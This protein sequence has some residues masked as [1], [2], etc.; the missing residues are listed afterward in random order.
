MPTASLSLQPTA[1][2]SFAHACTY[3]ATASTAVLDRVGE[4]SYARA[5][6]LAGR[7]LLISITASE[8]ASSLQL[9]V[10]GASLAADALEAAAAWVRHTFALD[11]DV[12]E[13]E[14]L[15]AGDPIFGS[16]IARYPGLRLTLIA[17]PFEAL[18][19]AV[20]G[21]QVNIAFA[22]KLRL[23]LLELSGREGEFAGGR[24]PLMPMPAAVAALD[25]AVLRARQ[26][27]QQKA[28]YVIGLATAVASGALDFAAV[29]ALPPAEALVY[30]T[31]FRG[32]GRWTAEYLL[33]RGLGQRDSIPAADVGLQTV[34]GRHY[35][36]GRKATEAEVR[37]LA[38]RWLG[39]HSWAAFYWWFA[40][41][42]GD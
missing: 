21:Q 26:F 17:E 28:S 38:E 42:R 30:L 33:M 18:L 8:E 40:L 29:A 7:D 39:W 20:I 35:G 10:S 41:Q 11:E 14:R 6:R 2:Y 37:R 22:R 9:T 32:V 27:S 5:V 31:G 15:G 36:Y 12:S 13:F 4:R 24:Y 34:I 25:P 1:P 16:L 19:W 3:L 23:T